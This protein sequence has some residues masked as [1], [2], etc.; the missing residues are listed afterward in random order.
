MKKYLYKLIIATLILLSTAVVSA[1]NE[2]YYTNK[3]NIDMTLEEYNNLL[4][5]GFT[6]SQI[7]YMTNETFLEN[8]DIEATLVSRNTQ[9]VKTTTFWRNGIAYHTSEILTEEEIMHDMELHNGE[10]QIQQPVN[11]PNTS[12]YCYNGVSYDYKVLT[13]SISFINDSTMRYKADVFWLEM[14]DTRSYDIIG[15][16]IEPSKVEINSSITFQQHYT[17]E[18]G[19]DGYGT[20]CN[21]KEQ[22]TGGS[23]LFKLPSG[24]FSDLE[25]YIYFNVTKVD[26]DEAITS[27]AAVGDYA[28]ATSSVTDSVFYYYTIDHVGGFDIDP[29]YYNSYDD[30]PVAVATFLGTW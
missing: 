3:N 10:L 25:S 15:I 23:V 1:T 30:L 16:G 13:A 18:N 26:S 6:E 14:P 2:V 17:Y 27:L 24:S 8:K 29:P 12:G 22:T 21:P 9:F 11:S 4:E 20:I 19:S 5:L 28:H 7:Y